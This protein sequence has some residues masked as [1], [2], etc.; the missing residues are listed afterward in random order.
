[1][2]RSNKLPAQYIEALEE[3]Y[4]LALRPLRVAGECGGAGFGFIAVN[5]AIMVGQGVSVLS[6]SSRSS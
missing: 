1:M 2:Y 6:D 4:I 5:Q 3:A